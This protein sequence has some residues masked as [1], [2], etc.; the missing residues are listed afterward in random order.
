M[1]EA[2]TDQKHV[3]QR[4]VGDEAVWSLSSAKPGNGVLQLRDGNKKN[5]II[6]FFPIH[7]K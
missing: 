7:N 5:I 3:D 4:E 2:S 1:E 6:S